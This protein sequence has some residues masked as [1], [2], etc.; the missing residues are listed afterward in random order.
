MEACL[1][2]HN[3][4]HNLKYIPNLYGWFEP[5]IQ[6]YEIQLYNCILVK[7]VYKKNIR[8]KYLMKPFFAGQSLCTIERE[9][10][11]CSPFGP[12]SSQERSKTKSLGFRGVG[13]DTFEQKKLKKL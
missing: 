1:V 10:T 11:I 7:T 6:L 13:H 12:V 8:E 2:D 5:Q 4:Q 9:S 3:A